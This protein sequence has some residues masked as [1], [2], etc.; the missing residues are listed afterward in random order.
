VDD[1]QDAVAEVHLVVEDIL[2]QIRA[3]A[4][5][6]EQAAAERIERLVQ[7]QRRLAEAR[8]ASTQMLGA[9]TRARV[10]GRQLAADVPELLEV[11]VLAPL[12]VSMPNG[13]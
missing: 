10:A 4:I 7:R 8:D 2:R 1:A 11:V 3:C 5:A 12:A 9:I 6:R 13:V